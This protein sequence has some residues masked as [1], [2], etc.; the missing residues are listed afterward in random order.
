MREAQQLLQEIAVVGGGRG[1][2]AGL[3]GWPLRPSGRDRFVDRR[4]EFSWTLRRHGNKVA[5]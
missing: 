3:G 2:G 5:E 1:P 4:R